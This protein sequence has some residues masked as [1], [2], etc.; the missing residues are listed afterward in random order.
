MV[1]KRAT[2]PLGVCLGSFGVPLGSFWG[3]LGLLLGCPWAP[4][5]PEALGAVLGG[6]AMGMWYAFL[7]QDLRFWNSHPGH[8]GHAGH[9]EVVS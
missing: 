6:G 8:A 4:M 3:A 7:Q 1:Y 9:A 5:D 2:P